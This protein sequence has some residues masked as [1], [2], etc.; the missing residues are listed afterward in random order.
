MGRFLARGVPALLSFYRRRWR[1]PPFSARP[2]R[3]GPGPRGSGPRCRARGISWDRFWNRYASWLL[4]HAVEWGLMTPASGTLPAVWMLDSSPGAWR[5]V[6]AGS[7]PWRTSP[8]GSIWSFPGRRAGPPPLPCLHGRPG[9]RARSP[10]LCDLR[11]G[12][13]SL[14]RSG[15]VALDLPLEHLRSEEPGQGAALT[16]WSSYEAPFSVTEAILQGR[17]PGPPPARGAGHRRLSVWG[18]APEE[19]KR[20][21]PL[22]TFPSEGEGEHIYRLPCPAQ[23]GTGLRLSCRTL[24]GGAYSADLPAEEPPRD[25]PPPL[26]RPERHR[27][28]PGRGGGGRP[29]RDAQLRHRGAPRRGHQ[30]EPRARARRRSQLRLPV[31]PRKR[32]P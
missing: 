27:S 20:V 22:A 10:G 19:S 26:G 4:A 30:G 9:A 29:A 12:P 31:S 2:C 18:R 1:S 7:S 11:P 23:D 6:R 24:A 17:G 3:R 25:G 8:R 28:R 13:L 21:L 14:P 16:L 32:S 15:D 5:D